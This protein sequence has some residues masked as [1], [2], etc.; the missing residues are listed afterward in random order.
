MSGANGRQNDEWDAVVIGSGIGGLVCAAYLAVGGKRVLVVE[1]AG[2]AG[3]NSH[4][5]RRRRAYEFDVG[6]HYLGDCGPGGLLPAILDGL[7]L[8]GRLTYREMDRDGFDRIVI[9][10]ATLDMPADWA[11]YRKRLQEAC[12]EDAAGIDT[13]LDV[14]AGL[15]AERRD[16]IIAAEDVPMPEL[17]R[18][19]PQSVAWGRR[20]LKEL[21]DHCGLSARARTLLAA[22]SPNYGMA[23]DEAT[24]ALHATVTDHYVRGAYYPEGGGQMLA[25]GL[26]E[27]VRA[28]GGALRTYSRVTRI[29]VDGGRTQGVEFSDGSRATAPVVVSNADYRRT[30]LGLVGAEKLP[31]RLAA[32]TR[33]ARMALPWAAVYVALDRDIGHH[34]N[35][36]W[37]R[38]DDIERFY[39]GLRAGTTRGGG[40]FLFASFA[41]GKD[42]VTRRICPPGHSNFQLMTL[43]P[44]GFESW[45]VS[46]GPADGEKYRRDASYQQE[47]A[48]LT[49]AVLDTAEE[50][51]GPF[52]DHITHLETA[53]PLTHER[54]TLSSGGTPFGMAHWG[55]AGARPDTATFVEGLYIAGAD[56]RYGNGITGSAV[57]GIACAGRILDR[58]LMH[59]VHTGAVLGD[60]SLLPE[61]H[62]DW[63]PLAVSR[64]DDLRL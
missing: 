64:G 31:R 8:A 50:A 29:L 62:T 10:G 20:T 16:A 42:P 55:A 38:G 23:P 5:F 14:V 30:M 48:R 12:P 39:D 26:L 49:E 15:G 32:K 17:P 61:R 11:A 41:S 56:T 57:S 45:G 27:V 25:A 21:F 63:D 1:Q 52:R 6:V 58:R 3:G 54:Y 44:P 51:L 4:V 34:A 13:F 22:Q 60:P 53:T 35:L 46:T 47:K 43:C 7:G 37:Y 18:H 33:D 59:E 40:D 28:Y 24:V 2:I 19:A 36:W 9:P